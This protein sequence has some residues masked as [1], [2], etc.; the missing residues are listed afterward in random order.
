MLLARSSLLVTSELLQ[1]RSSTVTKK[2]RNHCCVITQPE[3]KGNIDRLSVTSDCHQLSGPPHVHPAP[4]PVVCLTDPVSK[5]P[6]NGEIFQHLS[7]A[8][9]LGSSV[10][11]LVQLE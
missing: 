5:C 7:L 9:L 10:P 11:F 8:Y 6:H 2:E 3:R 1:W 4:S